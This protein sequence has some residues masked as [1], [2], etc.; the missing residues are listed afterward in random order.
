MV[1]VAQRDIID[2]WCYACQS[3]Y[4]VQQYYTYLI[5]NG[6]ERKQ[7]QLEVSKAR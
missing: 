5:C 4:Y 7:K 3:R 1:F 6:R 2:R